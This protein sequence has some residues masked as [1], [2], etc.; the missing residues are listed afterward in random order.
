[1]PLFLSFC[2]NSPRP[3]QDTRSPDFPRFL[4][5]TE[6]AGKDEA[7]TGDLDYQSP[8]PVLPSPQGSQSKETKP[9]GLMGRTVLSHSRG[10]RNIVERTSEQR[11]LTLEPLFSASVP[12]YYLCLL[13]SS[14]WVRSCLCLSRLCDAWSS[15]I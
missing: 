12:S 1:M 2:S 10:P 13:V 3:R 8:A 7:S 15:G 5:D 6:A 4:Q 9:S 14:S 11:R